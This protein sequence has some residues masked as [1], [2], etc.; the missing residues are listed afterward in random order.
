MPGSEA[1]PST[2]SASPVLVR[3]RLMKGKEWKKYVENRHPLGL[4]YEVKKTNIVRS[5]P[6]RRRALYGTCNSKCFDV[7]GYINI[8][9]TYI[10]GKHR[11]VVI[12]FQCQV[13]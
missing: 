8:K 3:K 6:H 1:A 4:A 13:L 7:V 11:S 2:P 9:N 5:W 10:E 12:C